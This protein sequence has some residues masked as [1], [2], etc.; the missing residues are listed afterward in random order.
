MVQ[1][2]AVTVSASAAKRV[3]P[4]AKIDDI[5]CRKERATQP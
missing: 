3:P 1:G 2:D 5:D 4:G